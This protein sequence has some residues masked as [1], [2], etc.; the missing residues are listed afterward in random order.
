MP[1]QCFAALLV[2]SAASGLSLSAA[3]R[4]TATRRSAVRSAAAADD[5]LR[6]PGDPSLLLHTNVVLTPEQKASFM[7]AASKSIA[8]CLGKPES[9]VAVCVVD[10]ASLIFGGSDAPSAIGCVY[11]LGSINKAP[12]GP[13]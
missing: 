5:P 10:G 3:A 1:R 12:P 11:S 4:P 7:S 8:S 6:L 13:P 9:Y 2:A